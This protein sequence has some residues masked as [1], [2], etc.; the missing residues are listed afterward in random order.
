MFYNNIFKKWPT[1]DRPD[2]SDSRFDKQFK[3]YLWDNVADATDTIGEVLRD[4]PVF[5]QDTIPLMTVLRNGAGDAY[6]HIKA[7]H[8]LYVLH[9]LGVRP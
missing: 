9:K 6:V 3:L 8:L 1:S 5:V 7:K 2:T 4:A